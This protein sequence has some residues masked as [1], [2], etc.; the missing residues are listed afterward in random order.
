[1]GSSENVYNMDVIGQGEHLEYENYFYISLTDSP[2]NLVLDVIGMHIICICEMYMCN[3]IKHLFTNALATEL[4]KKTLNSLS[5][6][7]PRYPHTCT[8]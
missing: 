6:T 2:D 8:F 1:M 4:E 5:V 7:F 3:V